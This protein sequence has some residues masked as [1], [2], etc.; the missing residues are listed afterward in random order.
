MANVWYPSGTRA[1]FDS[2]AEAGAPELLRSFLLGEDGDEVLGLGVLI[3][4]NEV[5]PTRD[6]GGKD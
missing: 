1:P 5:L 3:A 4:A 2:K 6:P